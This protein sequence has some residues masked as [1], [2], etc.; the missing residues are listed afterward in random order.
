MRFAQ[1]FINFDSEFENLK[2]S[3]SE[4]FYKADGGQM[5]FSYH[6]NSFATKTLTFWKRKFAVT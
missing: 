3:S 4:I 6:M 2:R 5:N 1:K